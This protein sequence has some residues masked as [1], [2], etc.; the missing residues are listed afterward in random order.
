M[1]YQEN[2]AQIL[3]FLINKAIQ[4]NEY[5]ALKESKESHLYLFDEFKITKNDILEYNIFSK[6]VDESFSYNY[7]QFWDDVNDDLKNDISFEIITTKEEFEKIK[8]D[9]SRK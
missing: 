7:E 3:E 8:N 2:N 6:T 4:N 5:I 1:I 9:I